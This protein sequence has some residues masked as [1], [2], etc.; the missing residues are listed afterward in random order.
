MSVKT[1]ILFFFFNTRQR[2]NAVLLVP[3]SKMLIYIKIYL[4][5]RWLLWNI[6]LKIQNDKNK[7]F[8]LLF[9]TADARTCDAEA[10][11]ARFK[12]AGERSIW[13]TKRYACPFHTFPSYIAISLCRDGDWTQFWYVIWNNQKLLKFFIVY[14][15]PD[16][17]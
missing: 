6:S 15:G 4:H 2:T 10:K 14:L 8:S 3:A 9:S 12:M 17:T 11:M 16:I 5:S 7:R 13:P 1:N